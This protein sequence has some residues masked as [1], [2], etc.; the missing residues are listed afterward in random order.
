MNTI[1]RIDKEY[2]YLIVAILIANK[3]V[4]KTKKIIKI[5]NFLLN[6]IFFN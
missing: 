3:F 4:G 2:P 5:I 1:K 6:K